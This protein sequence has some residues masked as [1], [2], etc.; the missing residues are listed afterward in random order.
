[1]AIPTVLTS[2]DIWVYIWAFGCH[3][4]VDHLCDWQLPCRLCS[5]HGCCCELRVAV[6]PN[7]AQIFPGLCPHHGVFGLFWWPHVEYPPWRRHLWHIYHVSDSTAVLAA[8][9]QN[10]L[11]QHHRTADSSHSHLGVCSM[12]WLLSPS[13]MGGV[14]RYFLYYYHGY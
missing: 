2:A 5:E 11:C 12:E 14:S 1:V 6:Y 4:W 10:A 7:C 3:H 8:F 13:E 9:F